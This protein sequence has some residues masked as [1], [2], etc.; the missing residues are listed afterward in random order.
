MDRYDTRESYLGMNIVGWLQGHFSAR[1]KALCLYRRGMAKAKNRDFRGAIDVYTTTLNVPN[2]PNDVLAMV[3]YNRAM[4][5]VANGDDRQ[6]VDDLEA[7]LQM[8]DA[9]INVKSLARVKLDKV[10]ARSNRSSC[11]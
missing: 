3:L 6:C 10:E 2:A 1:G 11:R 9:S 8:D 7:V 4:A 5:H